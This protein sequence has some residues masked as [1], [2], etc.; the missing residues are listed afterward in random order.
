MLLRRLESE[1]RVAQTGDVMAGFWHLIVLV[2]FH[3]G[4]IADPGQVV[5]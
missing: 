4:S 3:T 5:P 1:K 2:M